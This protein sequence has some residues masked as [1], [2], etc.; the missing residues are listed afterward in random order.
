MLSLSLMEFTS[1]GLVPTAMPVLPLFSGQKVTCCNQAF[2]APLPPD[3]RTL[4][5]IFSSS[6]APIIDASPIGSPLTLM[7]LAWWRS[8]SN[9]CGGEGLLGPDHVFLFQLEGLDVKV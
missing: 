2:V 9:C 8:S 6:Q 4:W 7:S 1:K 3:L 5:R